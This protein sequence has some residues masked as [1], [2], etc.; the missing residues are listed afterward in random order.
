MRLDG[1]GP[2]GRLRCQD[3]AGPIYDPVAEILTRVSGRD[4][5]APILCEADQHP[6]QSLQSRAISSL[7][8]SGGHGGPPNFHATSP[9]RRLGLSGSLA[10][11]AKKSS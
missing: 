1:L 7:W 3:F 10:P 11:R 5:C 2:R 8:V 4:A 9:P 6:G